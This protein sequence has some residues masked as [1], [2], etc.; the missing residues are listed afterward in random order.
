MHH[1]APPLAFCMPLGTYNQMARSSAHAFVLAC[2]LAQAVREEL[3]LKVAI[4]AERF[5][6]KFEWY[7]DVILK[8]V[9]VG[10]SVRCH[11]D[12]MMR[13][14]LF[15]RA[16][17]HPAAPPRWRAELGSARTAGLQRVYKALAL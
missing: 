7:V 6:T 5:A 13:P 2:A 14:C 3:V 8:L 11:D 10:G 9:Q 17:S 16:P 15:L 4:M 1:A 12:M